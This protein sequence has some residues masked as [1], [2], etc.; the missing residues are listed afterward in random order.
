MQ[1]ICLQINVGV[2]G[3]NKLYQKWSFKSVPK[4]K[5]RID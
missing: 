5:M 2:N 3:R 4:F 1:T